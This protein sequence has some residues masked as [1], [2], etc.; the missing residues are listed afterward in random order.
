MTSR[1]NK[2]I[3]KLLG[4]TK[5]DCAIGLIQLDSEVCLVVVSVTI[6]SSAIDSL[7]ITGSLVEIISFS[8]FCKRP[9]ALNSVSATVVVEDS[10]L[11]AWSVILMI[12]S[13]VLNVP[14]GISISPATSP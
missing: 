3:G 5:K 1:K 8:L 2:P 7:L 10:S 11:L 14:A 9:F 4:S 13:P 12:L 6:P